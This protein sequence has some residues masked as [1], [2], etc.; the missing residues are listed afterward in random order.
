M[1]PNSKIL[2]ICQKNTHQKIYFIKYL[3]LGSGAEVRSKQVNKM[4]GKEAE[5][6]REKLGFSAS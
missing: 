4:F 2:L 5:A 3:N 6:V 1:S